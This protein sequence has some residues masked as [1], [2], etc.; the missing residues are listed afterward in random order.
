MHGIC[1]EH[2]QWDSMQRLLS[3]TNDVQRNTHIDKAL[4]GQ[5]NHLPIYLKDPSTRGYENDLGFANQVERGNLLPGSFE[6]PVGMIE[7]ERVHRHVQNLEKVP[8]GGSRNLGNPRVLFV[9]LYSLETFVK[10]ILRERS[11][12][13]TLVLTL[14][15]C[16]MR[17][18]TKLI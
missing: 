18:L 9:R 7:E 12:G 2:E 8:I 6:S 14:Y 16:R 3:Q 5:V 15:T 1:L 17:I 13:C 4:L 11:F 10:I